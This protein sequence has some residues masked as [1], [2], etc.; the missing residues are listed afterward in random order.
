[1]VLPTV[2][3]MYHPLLFMHD[4]CT[5][6]RNSLLVC[7]LDVTSLISC[8]LEESLFR[9]RNYL[10]AGCLPSMLRTLNSIQVSNTGKKK[11]EE[12]KILVWSLTLTIWLWCVLECFSL[13]CLSCIP[14]SVSWLGVISANI[15]FNKLSTPFS[16]SSSFGTP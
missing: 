14:L 4:L 15:S 3:W 16:L 11:K 13:E 10:K 12:K 8:Y 2:F 7:S 9:S 5:N 1:M 6:F